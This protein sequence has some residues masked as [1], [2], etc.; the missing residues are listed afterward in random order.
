MPPSMQGSN[1]DES[2]EWWEFELPERFS[3]AEDQ[4][5]HDFLL[6][7]VGA[8]VR[9][10]FRRL[11]RLD[12]LLLQYLVAAQRAWTAAGQAFEVA[13]VPASIDEALKRLG[14]EADMLRWK[15]V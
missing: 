13:D 9:L 15:G 11:R 6:A 1:P 14:V 2:T 7:G 12:C 4:T 3:I 5:L 10:S 8:P